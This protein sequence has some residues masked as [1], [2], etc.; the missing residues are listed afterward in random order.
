MGVT[1]SFFYSWKIALVSLATSPL[2]ILGGV[3]VQRFQWR[4]KSV[5]KAS[6]SGVLDPYEEANALLSDMILNYK[7]VIGFGEKNIH[8]IIEK[9]DKLL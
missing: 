8:Y 3:M 5:I 1:L 7:T 4:N 2:I 9:F 6:D